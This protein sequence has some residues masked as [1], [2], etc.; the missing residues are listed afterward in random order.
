MEGWPH[1]SK[2][3][4]FYNSASE[5]IISLNSLNESKSNKYFQLVDI[6][7]LLDFSEHSEDYYSDWVHY[8]PLSREI[9]AKRIFQDIEKKVKENLN[10]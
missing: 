7:N 2:K 3:Q 6:S 8:N 5:K 1:L 10:D 9:I 4:L